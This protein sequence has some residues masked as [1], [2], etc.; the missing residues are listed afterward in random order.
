MVSS[1]LRLRRSH[2]ELSDVS[3]KLCVGGG[4][5]NEYGPNRCGVG[6]SVGLGTCLAMGSDGWGVKNLGGERR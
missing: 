2:S 5:S 1:R 4:S 3:V 6:H